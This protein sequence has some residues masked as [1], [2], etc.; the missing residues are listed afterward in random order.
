MEEIKINYGDILGLKANSVFLRGSFIDEDKNYR[1]TEVVVQVDRKTFLVALNQ[2][3]DLKAKAYEK[4]GGFTGKTYMYSYNPISTGD[5]H[6]LINLD[7]TKYYEVP[8]YKEDKIS[9]EHK[10]C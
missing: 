9:V 5:K 4:D 8:I 2:L 6:L 1:F 3:L 10:D 7:N